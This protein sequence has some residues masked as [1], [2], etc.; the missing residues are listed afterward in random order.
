MP[1]ARDADLGGGNR[2]NELEGR[3]H[4]KNVPRLKK[5]HDRALQQADL[6]HHPGK[7]QT[8]VHITT[9]LVARSQGESKRL[10]GPGDTTSLKADSPI[11]K[12]KT[13]GGNGGPSRKEARRVLLWRGKLLGRDY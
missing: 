8:G 6:S 2:S 5:R 12:G 10:P 7:G 11:K 9:S 3:E 13:G 1:E 4:D